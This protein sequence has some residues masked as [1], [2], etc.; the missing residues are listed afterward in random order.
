MSDADD[1]FWDDL[2][3]VDEG[4]TPPWLHLLNPLQRGWRETQLLKGRNPD[5][6]F[7]KQ[8]REDGVW[9]ESNR[10]EQ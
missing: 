2:Y 4:T 7:E 5:P 6:H 1:E 10:T 8:L 3:D 9:P